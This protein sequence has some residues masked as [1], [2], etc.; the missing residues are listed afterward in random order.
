VSLRSLESAITSEAR[1][2]FNNR[3]LRVKD[4]QEWSTAPIKPEAGEVAEHLP[5]NNVY[6]A[7]K[8][9]HDKRAQ[10]GRDAMD[11]GPSK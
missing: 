3:T 5:L 4:L 7:I 2:H 11:G 9:E 10:L 1:R 6:V 8:V